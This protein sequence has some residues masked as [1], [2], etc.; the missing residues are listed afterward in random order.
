MH[1]EILKEFPCP[2]KYKT[3]LQFTR[4]QDILKL[5]QA[6]EHKLLPKWTMSYRE[7][8]KLPLEGRYMPGDL[9]VREIS[10]RDKSFPAVAWIP[11]AKGFLKCL[12]TENIKD[13]LHPLASEKDG[14][15]S[16]FKGDRHRP[17]EERVTSLTNIHEFT[18][19]LASMLEADEELR[20]TLL[21]QSHEELSKLAGFY[22]EFNDYVSTAREK[23]CTYIA[24]T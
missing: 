7:E 9:F 2:D 14:T 5:Y 11:L 6:H 13:R 4:L 10:S 8:K 18:L 1:T 15:R 16:V 20:R 21:Y 17:R 3:P 12:D 19:A 22:P 23:Q 24:Q